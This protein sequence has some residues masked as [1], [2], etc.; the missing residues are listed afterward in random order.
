MA[1]GRVPR[2]VLSRRN[3]TARR[4]AEM[5]EIADTGELAGPELPQGVLADGESWLPQT[6]ALWAELRRSPLMRDEPSLTWTYMIDTAVLHHDM[7]QHGEL[8]HAAELRLRLAKIGITPEDRQRLKVRITQRV[9]APQAP[10][11]VAD[12][13][14]R[15]ARL[16]TGESVGG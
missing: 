14:A 7:W 6:Q 13:A 16:T 15:R 1:K 2:D 10:A 11:G 4:Q 12:I 8:K 5:V 9:E 3:D